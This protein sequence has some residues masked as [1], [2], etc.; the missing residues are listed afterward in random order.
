MKSFDKPYLEEQKLEFPRAHESQQLPRYRGSEQLKTP[1]VKEK[2][3]AT[4]EPTV[5]TQKVTQWAQWTMGTSWAPQIERH[6][7][8]RT[9]FNLGEKEKCSFLIVITFSLF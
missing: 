6:A 5:Y 7:T 4:L 2:S 9:P 1:R 8:D 3:R